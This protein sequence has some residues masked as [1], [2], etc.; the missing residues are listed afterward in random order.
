MNWLTIG[1]WACAFAAS[2][3]T[4]VVVLFAM[5]ERRNHAV[6]MQ[7]IDGLSETHMAGLEVLTMD[8]DRLKKRVVDLEEWRDEP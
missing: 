3:C 5:M 6:A 2:A 4:I 7:A 8:V 1:V